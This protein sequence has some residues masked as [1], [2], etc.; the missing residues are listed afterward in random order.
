MTK[1]LRKAVP[2]GGMAVALLITASAHGQSI[3]YTTANST[4]SQNFDTLA[5]S[6]TGHVF[7]NDG[8]IAGFYSNRTAYNA[9]TGSSTAGALYSFGASGSSER[10][11]GSLA[12]G[13]ATPIV[14]G[15]RLKNNTGLTLTQFTLSYTGEQWRNSGSGNANT[16]TFAYGIGATSLTLGTYNTVAALGFTGPVASGSAGALNGNLS[17]NR[18]ALSATLTDIDWAPGSDLWLRWTDSDD[19]GSDHALAIDDLRFSAAGPASSPSGF[20]QVP[21]PTSLVLAAT[22]LLPLAGV[23]RRSRVL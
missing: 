19:T 21:E 14:F 2:I 11:L 18:M 22:G 8:T 23:R 16:L 3:G 4:Y 1:Q 17:A 15:A 9:G 12:S 5:L 13:T 10:A 7:T 20:P 6:G